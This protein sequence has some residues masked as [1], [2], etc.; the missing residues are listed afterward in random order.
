VATSDAK[1]RTT[2]A[3]E[4][5]GATALLRAARRGDRDAFDALARR[6]APRLVG[7]ARRILRDPAEA[8]EAA[9]DALLRAFSALPTL[10]DERAFSAWIHRIACR[11]AVD[12]LRARRARAARAT[13]LPDA[14]VDSRPASRP[15]F[16]R[17]ADAERVE[18]V[19]RAMDRLPPAQRLAMV[20]HV[21]EG[22]SYDDAAEVLGTSYDAVR[23]NVAH[24]R[25][26]LFALLRRAD[27]GAS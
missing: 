27:G 14:A 1:R 5:E 7:A 2:P 17:L 11:C 12:R 6:H 20:L 4:A 22:L 25:R 8:E 15:P 21:W 23:V 19:R 24:A 18:E 10:A 13:P 16:A 3:E 26:A 9:A